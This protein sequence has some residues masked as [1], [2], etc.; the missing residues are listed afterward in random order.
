MSRQNKSTHLRRYTD[1]PFLLDYLRTKELVLLSPKMWDDKNDRHC[2]ESYARASRFDS[3]YAL[4]LTEA[5]E[6]YH[7]WK[8][9]T[10]GSSGV[11][12]EFKKDDLIRFAEKVSS[13][14]AEPV[15]YQTIKELKIK[16]PTLEQL[17]FLKRNAFKDESEFRL[18]VANNNP[19]CEPLRFH[20]PASA[21]NRVILS[22]WIS[23]V[24]AK[25]VIATLN[26]IKGCKTLKVK[27]SLLI[28][29]ESWKQLAEIGT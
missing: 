13:L 20:V 12:I 9:F 22:P 19:S 14:R 21:V 27:R 28:D 23:D 2:L 18:F 25:Q 5:S 15:Q 8:V 3:I 6:T 29:N 24:V 11:C 4:C 26:E 17:P 16:R 7:H 10:S 1:I